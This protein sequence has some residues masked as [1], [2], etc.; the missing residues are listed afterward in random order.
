MC[1]KNEDLHWKSKKHSQNLV[2]EEVGGFEVCAPSPLFSG[3][4]SQ[5]LDSS[6]EWGKAHADTTELVLAIEEECMGHSL[7]N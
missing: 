1:V 5:T 4:M 2:L 6:N 7:F 3:Q